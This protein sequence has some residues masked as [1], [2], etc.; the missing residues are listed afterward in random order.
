MTDQDLLKGATA[1]LATVCIVILSLPAFGVLLSSFRHLSGYGAVG[2]HYEDEDGA[3]TEESIKAY[4]DLRP[5]I[6]VWLSL[7]IGLGT[8]ISARVLALR[9]RRLLLPRDDP[10]AAVVAWSGVVSWASTH[11]T[12]GKQ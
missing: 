8:S 12:F 7:V 11:S 4:S 3:A 6:A 2:G 5:R 10:W 9:S 1:L